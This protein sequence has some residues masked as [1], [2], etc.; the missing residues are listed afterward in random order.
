MCVGDS[1]YYSGL[2]SRKF[3]IA[4]WPFCCEVVSV[5]IE[6]TKYNF[7]VF[8]VRYYSTQVA[9]N[10]FTTC[11]STARI[12]VILRTIL[13][14][15]KLINAINSVPLTSF[16]SPASSAWPIHFSV[17]CFIICL[18]SLFSLISHLESNMYYRQS[19][20]Q[21]VFIQFS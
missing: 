19:T 5:E 15:G 10:F 21:C 4:H 16:S 11:P 12:W 1:E 14:L 13:S 8:I 17:A 3:A 7:T 6:R 9:L 2:H 18:V 20:R